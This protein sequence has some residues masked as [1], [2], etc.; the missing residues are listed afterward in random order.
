MHETRLL[1]GM[2]ITVEIVDRKAS[3]KD[4]D[5]IFAYFQEIDNRFSTYKENSEI[6]KLN[7]H[8]IK[9]KDLSKEMKEVLHLSELT[10]QETNGYF[11]I[12]KLNGLIDPSGMVKGWAIWQAAQ[13]LTRDGFKNFFIDAGGDIQVAGENGKGEKWTVG[14]RNPFNQSE[15]I[16]RVCLATEGIATTGTYVRGQHVYNPF[17]PSAPLQTIVSLTVIGPNIYEADRFA[18]ACFAMQKMSVQFLERQKGLEGYMIDTNGIATMT[19][20]FEKYVV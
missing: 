2:P 6:S 14:I 19:S 10:K 1:M 11:D 12:K 3:Q 13:Q 9:E 17:A 8:E 7:R 4:I 20:G 16:K 18:T 15:I 5:A